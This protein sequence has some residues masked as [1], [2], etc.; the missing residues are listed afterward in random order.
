MIKRIAFS[1]TFNLSYNLRLKENFSKFEGDERLKMTG[2]MKSFNR[3][4]RYGISKSN[5]SFSN[6][7]DINNNYQRS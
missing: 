3:P 4:N 2:N 6:M 1:I 7:A 5:A